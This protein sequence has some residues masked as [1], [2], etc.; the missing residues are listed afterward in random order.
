MNSKT[1]DLSPARWARVEV[2][3]EKASSLPVDARGAYLGEA[4]ADDVELGEYVLSLLHTDPGIDA[5]VENAIVN[6]VNSAFGDADSAEADLQGAMIGPYRVKRLLGEGGMGLVYLADRADEQ[7]DQQV[8][9]KL[10]R[11][12]LLDPMTESRLRSERQI[13]ANLDHPNI[14]RLF[15]GGTSSH[16]VPYLVMEYIDGI[17]IDE[18]CNRNRLSLAER[19]ELFQVIC[20][21]VHY[22]HQNLVIHRDIKASNILVTDDG[23]PKLLDFGIAKLVDTQG[24]AAAGLTREGAVVMTPENA[25]PEQVLGR[26]I[27]TATDTYAL[28]LLLHALLTGFPAY[29]LEDRTPV[30]MA[31]VICH[32]EVTSPSVLLKGEIAAARKADA[33]GHRASLERIARERRVSLER[34][35]RRLR[36]DLDTIVLKSL[37]KEPERRYR[38]VN[39]FA[40]DIAL[41][42]NRMPIVARADSW[43]YRSG[44]FIRRHYAGVSMS[45]IAV[46]VLAGFSIVLSVQNQRIKEER[47]LAQEVSHFLED[48]F[49]SP[50]P[51]RARGLDITAKEILAVGAE[52]I[53][54]DLAGRPVIQSALM[55]TI[56]R[57]YF[58]LGE[59]QPSIDML[60]RSIEL[61]QQTL[62][63]Q[64]PSVAQ[65]KNELAEAL[66]RKADYERA[67][68][69]LEE[70]LALNRAE[71]GE[72]SLPVADNLFNLAE[73][74]LR[75]GELDA[76]EGF[77][78]ASIDIYTPLEQQYGVELAEAKNTLARILQVRGNLDATETLLREAID[79]VESNEGTDHP[80]MA[81]YLQNLGV[82]LQSKGDLDAAEETLGQAIEATRRIL[83][84]KHDLVATT[85]A[86]QGAV[87]HAKGDYDAAE[88]ALRDAL[89]LDREALGPDHPFVGYDMVSL[90]MLLHD[91]GE[92]L[93]AESML[94]DALDIYGRALAPDHQYIASALT[95]LGAVMNSME[96]PSEATDLLQTAIG[97]RRKDYPDDNVLVAATRSEYGDALVSLG[98]F[99]EAESI[100]EESYQVLHEQADRRARRA[101]DALI[102]LYEAT[103][104]HD[105]AARI[106]ARMR[107]SAPKP[108]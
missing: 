85:L 89:A 12:K 22:A 90:G 1:I 91:K 27:T 49:M 106:R 100:L 46:I 47:D 86:I 3:Y 35:Q 33:A 60:E 58:N 2:L 80:L 25:A 6:A 62:G 41:H 5:T 79:I 108:R 59:Y 67:R 26:S 28:G 29:S 51:A 24:A 83:G 20:S 45:I 50:D 97:I 11:Q 52:R 92:L 76:A 78:N 10:G 69:L 40:E 8:A 23:T 21:A 93:Q 75:T 65:A 55:E 57:V 56:G 84:R 19:L 18:Y 36:G 17:R 31:N 81:Y 64:H 44:K 77:A 37:R 32:G 74:H 30:E 61:R 16:G 9:I 102:R 101:A 105:D 73:L 68:Q 38:S 13:L 103:D 66:I 14:A 48:I 15:D 95:E 63:D 98:R 72:Q 96:R 71:H 107:E 4:C 53:S 7:F 104:R 87:Q 88:D 82:L 54:R 43:R 42:L 34:L 39:Q 70:S 99:D 94:G